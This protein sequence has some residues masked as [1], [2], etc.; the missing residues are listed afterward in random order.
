MISGGSTIPESTTE[1]LQ[2][3]IERGVDL[4]GTE[5][6]PT[7]LRSGFLC[8]AA[9][10]QKGS[11]VPEPVRYYNDQ[12]S[13]YIYWQGLAFR[14]LGEEEKA[15]KCFHQL[16]IFGERHLHD[17][18]GYDYFAVSLP[19]LESYHD[20]IQKRSDDYCRRLMRLGWEGILRLPG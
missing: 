13:D 4:T 11:S 16:I 19:E 20:D 15:R 1:L 12:P 17:R 5:C 18:M 2:L 8:R 6:T 9:E 7:E 3:P 10:S 14:E